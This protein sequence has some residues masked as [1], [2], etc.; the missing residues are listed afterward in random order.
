MTSCGLAGTPAVLEVLRPDLC[1]A[2]IPCMIFP[3]Q[4]YRQETQSP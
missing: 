1:F 4:E 3:E 2:D